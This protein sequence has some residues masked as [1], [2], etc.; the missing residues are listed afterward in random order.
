MKASSVVRK[1]GGWL[2]LCSL[3]MVSGLAACKENLPPDQRWLATASEQ[4]VAEHETMARLTEKAY[5]Q[6]QSF[7]QQP[8]EK[9]LAKMQARW[10]DGMDS[11]QRLQWVRFGPISKNN[12]D[13]KLQ[14]WPD[15]KNILQRKVQVILEGTDPITLDSLAHASVVVQGFSAQEL[16]L[17]DT[18]FAQVERFPGRQCDLLLA[19]TGLT[20]NVAKG[21]TD[22]WK[23]KAWL[24]TWLNPKTAP[25]GE[26]A[27]Q[28]R[29]G[30]LLDALLAQVEKIKADKFGEP[31][32]QK[33]RD[34]KPN[35]YFA[36]SWRSQ[37]SLNNIH[38]NLHALQQL[39]TPKSGYGL[40]QYLRDR[41]QPEVADELVIKL[42]N[43]N[44]ALQQI[45]VPLQE[46]VKD[47]AMQEPLQQVF[48]SLSEMAS[49][50]KKKLAPALGLSLGFN[51]NDGD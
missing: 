18:N 29:D 15:K 41:Q 19:T 11:W 1:F 24:Q 12:E 35:G 28:T 17:F 38:N 43:I 5:K 34:K 21:L 8:T 27:A 14:F 44:L 31:M 45:S 36:E 13:W 49:F 2:G 26:T 51:S 10:R 37:H 3:V 32:G 48:A 20:A 39:S 7:C 30:E 22:G 9:G 40:Y 33:T 42:D 6:A 23:D 16:L 46:A 4:I 50:I 47:P 25:A